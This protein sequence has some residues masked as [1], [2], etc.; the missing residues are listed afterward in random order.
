M[1]SIVFEFVPSE[2]LP[3][4]INVNISSSLTVFIFS[5]F[6]VTAKSPLAFFELTTSTSWFFLLTVTLPLSVIS[7]LYESEFSSV[8]V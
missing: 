1:I 3:L 8:I 5:T 7:T 6:F 2:N 4:T